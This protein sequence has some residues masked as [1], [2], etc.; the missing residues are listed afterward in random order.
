MPPVVTASN[1]LEEASEALF[2]RERGEM[3]GRTR[4]GRDVTCTRPPTLVKGSPIPMSCY[5]NPALD[6]KTACD[7]LCMSFTP[8]EKRRG[9]AIASL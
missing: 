1:R 9:S 2:K 8:L 5:M 7:S 6:S 3:Q 4:L